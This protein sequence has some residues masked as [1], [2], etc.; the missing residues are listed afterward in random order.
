MQDAAQ[1]KRELVGLFSHIQRIRYEIAAIR[2]P[3]AD[4][5]D[6]FSKMS[7]ELDA[8]VASTEDATNTIM[9]SVERIEELV[10]AA[11][12][13]V[14]DPAAA[15][16]LDEVDDRIGAVFEACAFQDIT[17]QRVTKVVKLLMFIEE[18]VNSLVSIWGEDELASTTVAEAEKGEY[19]KYLNGP[20][21]KGGGVSQADIDRMLGGGGTPPAPAATAPKVAAQ[22]PVPAK[23]TAAPAAAKAPAPPAAAK[24][25][26]PAAA[27]PAA[28][29][30][31]PAK[32]VAPK[33]VAAAPAPAPKP[34]AP[35]AAPKPAA[36][37]AAV[38]PPP[39]P[40]PAPKADDEAA[41]AGPSFSQD[42]IDK[43]F[44]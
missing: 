18:R 1:L 34:V 40:A 38:K 31:P 29:S 27:K 5:G 44:G 19:E 30:P 28:P 42:D 23:P 25:A 41:D 8:I 7:D 22:A 6:N 36:P 17:G 12:P 33:P 35:P 21:L 10:T 13:H 32:P 20:Q 37:P 26:Q 15:A 11:K 43:L 2:K 9:E 39:P 16:A 3:G 14:G 24:P 4:D